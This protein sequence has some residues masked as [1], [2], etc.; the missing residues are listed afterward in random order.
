[1]AFLAY[2]L[3]ESE[4]RD[5]RGEPL[6]RRRQC[7]VETVA[8][9]G[10]ALMVSRPL[11]ADDWSELA[12][13]RDTARDYGTEGLMLK[14]YGSPYRVGRTRGDWWKWKLAPLTIDAVMIYAWYESFTDPAAGRAH[15]KYGTF[16][17]TI[18]FVA[19]RAALLV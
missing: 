19:G 7:L 17:A 12:R 18:A 15:F 9:G 6:E 8:D 10:D 5:W 2:D 11:P 1:M 4:G 13:Y 16:L 14:R 3:L